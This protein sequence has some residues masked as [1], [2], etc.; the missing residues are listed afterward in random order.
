MSKRKD[1]TRVT[2]PV[3]EKEL[4]PHAGTETE[5]TQTLRHLPGEQN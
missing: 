5:V 2:A 3:V 1:Q 4:V